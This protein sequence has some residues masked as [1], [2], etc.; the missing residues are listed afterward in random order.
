[1]TEAI[2]VVPVSES[3]LRRDIK[4]GKLSVAEDSRG[5][6]R[7]DAAELVRVYGN[8]KVSEPATEKQPETT[9][10]TPK[11]VSLLEAQVADLKGQLETAHERERTLTAERGEIVGLAKGLQKQNEM[12][13]LPPP[14]PEPQPERPIRTWLQRILG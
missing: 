12:L 10:D 3:T 8:L 5:R 7:I 14:A 6:R 4:S 9:S 11:V 1:M 2:K 13:M